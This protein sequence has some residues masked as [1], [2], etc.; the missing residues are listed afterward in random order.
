MDDIDPALIDKVAAFTGRCAALLLANRACLRVLRVQHFPSVWLVP[1]GRGEKGCSVDVENGTTAPFAALLTY[2]RGERG[3]FPSCPMVWHNGKLYILGGHAWHQTTIEV[4]DP[5]RDVWEVP[6]GVSRTPFFGSPHSVIS[7][8]G[9]IFAVG[10]PYLADEDERWF[11]TEAELFSCDPEREQPEQPDEVHRRIPMGWR[12]E[13]ALLTPR[14]GAQLVICCDAV[15]AVG[16]WDAKHDMYRESAHLERYDE[17][18]RRWIEVQWFPCPSKG[19]AVVALGGKIYVLGGITTGCNRAGV[20]SPGNSR[21][22][23]H[24]RCKETLELVHCYDPET[25]AWELLASLKTKRAYCKAVA[26]DGYIYAIGGVDP[27]T[28]PYGGVRRGWRYEPPTPVTTIE[29]Y[30][31]RANEWTTMPVNLPDWNH[32]HV[33]VA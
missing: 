20:R 23:D 17:Q 26:R 31:P 9:R 10:K 32:F 18:T 24:R 30:D 7:F 27:Y 25:N 29:R 16:G 3:D 12:P 14:Q 2:R 11:W 21:R 1:K 33:C 6:R 5:A 4:Y 8:R 19:L 28:P 13:E 15:W 22:G